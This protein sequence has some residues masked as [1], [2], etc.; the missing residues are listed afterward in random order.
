MIKNHATL[1]VGSNEADLMINMDEFFI[2]AGEEC[3]HPTIM[4]GGYS[5]TYQDLYTDESVPN[6]CAVP[7]NRGADPE[8]RSTW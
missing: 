3:G 1:L 5:A 7:A 4:G 6:S 8:D 2:K